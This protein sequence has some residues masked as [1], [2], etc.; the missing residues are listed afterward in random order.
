MNV[1]CRG[2]DHGASKNV[3]SVYWWRQ[4]ANWVLNESVSPANC[5]IC[6]NDQLSFS[7]VTKAKSSI[8][9]GD[10]TGSQGAAVMRSSS[11]LLHTTFGPLFKQL[12]RD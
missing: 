2:Y 12:L 3:D 6:E 5:V 7:L 11:K 8:V 4:I 10:S 1:F 9:V